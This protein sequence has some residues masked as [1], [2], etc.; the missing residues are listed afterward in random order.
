VTF[1]T[2]SAA[3]RFFVDKIVAQAESESTP[4]SKTERDMLSFSE[5]DPEFVIDPVAL[6]SQLNEE[7]TDDEYE[8]K[9]AGLIERSFR[10]DAASDSRLPPQWHEARSVLARGDHYL[11]I[12]IDR[13]LGRPSAISGSSVLLSVFGKSVRLLLGGLAV[14]LGGATALIG[15]LVA[16]TEG[17]GWGQLPAFVMSLLLFTFGAYLIRNARRSGAS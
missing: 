17:S 14:L 2:Q 3:K 9:I 15:L 16:V 13:A 4:L 5:S 11:L 8:A 10:K 7:E 6:S 12:M 1:S